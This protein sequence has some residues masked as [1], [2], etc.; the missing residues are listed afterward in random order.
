MCRVEW[1]D[2]EFSFRNVEVELPDRYTGGG[3]GYS[4][5]E[6]KGVMAGDTDLGFINV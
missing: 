6:V 3:S 5:R 2:Y 4:D 1:N